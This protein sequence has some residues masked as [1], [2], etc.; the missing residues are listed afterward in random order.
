MHL[1]NLLQII[2]KESMH[3]KMQICVSVFYQH[4]LGTKPL[5]L[6]ASFP[7]LQ[8]FLLV[9]NYQTTALYFEKV[10]FLKFD[11]M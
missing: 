3:L 6:K 1:L 7:T 11:E 9:I 5:Y 4:K 2:K 10:S 8:L